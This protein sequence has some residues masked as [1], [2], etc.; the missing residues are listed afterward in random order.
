VTTRSVAS[1]TTATDASQPRKAASASLLGT[2]VGTE[3]I[4]RARVQ[5]G[6]WRRDDDEY[7]ADAP[8]VRG[9]DGPRL[10]VAEVEWPQRRRGIRTLVSRLVN[11]FALADAP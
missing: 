1:P 5:R 4:L 11:R 8:D 3:T 6:G 2:E 9:W 10:V 7:D